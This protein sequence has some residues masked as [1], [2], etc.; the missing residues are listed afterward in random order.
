[1]T[2]P[3]ILSPEEDVTGKETLDFFAEAHEFNQWMFSALSPYCKDNILEIGSGIGNISKLLLENYNQV[4]LSD[5]REKYCDILVKQ[6]SG[7]PHL[8]NVYEFDLGEPNLHQTHPILI[9]RFDSV[10]ASNVVE[11]VEDDRLAIRNC[12]DMLKPK[13]RLVVLVP[14]YGFL[15]NGLDKELGHFRRYKRD[16]VT[17]LL[18]AEGFSVIHTQYFNATGILGWWFSGSVQKKTILPKN[19]LDLYNKLIPFIR[20]IDKIVWNRMGLSLITVG[21][22]N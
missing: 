17:G 11:H 1:M 10:I 4:C 2:G 7:N 3:E 8:Q 18:A 14:A 21:E 22:K 9:G 13:G 16:S 5:L 6:F 19:Q 12:Y 15:Y 20:L